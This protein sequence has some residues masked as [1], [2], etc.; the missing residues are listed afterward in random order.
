MSQ[1]LRIYVH[2]NPLNV[3]ETN[4]NI[5]LNVQDDTSWS[6]VC[7]LIKEKVNNSFTKSLAF[8]YLDEDADY[9]SGC[10]EDEWKEAIAAC[11]TRSRDELILHIEAVSTDSVA[12]QSANIKPDCCFRDPWCCYERPM[13]D[14]QII[15]GPVP[16]R[17]VNPQSSSYKYA[18][19]ALRAVTLPLGPIGGGSIALAGD[20]GL[21]EWQVVNE[22]C[23]LAHVPNSFFA[24]KVEDE[25]TNAAN[26]V[27]LQ[28]NMWYDESGFHPAPIVQDHIVPEAS[29]E[30]LKTLPGVKTIEVT[31]K[32]PIA[33]VDVTSTEVPVQVHLE[34]FNP[35]IP[36]NANDSAI[37]MIIFN[38]T[39]TNPSDKPVKVT[40]LTSLL[41]FIGWDGL[42]TIETDNMPNTPGG[43]QNTLY[44]YGG[45]I[46]AAEVPEYKEISGYY[47]IYMNNIE[48]DDKRSTNGELSIGVFHK[49][50]D[51]KSCLLQF[52]DVKG[53]WEDF[54]S[55][56]GLSGG[57][58]Q[59]GPSDKLKTWI[60]ALSCRREIQAG[61]S[62]TF[63]FLLSWHF[64][65]RYCKWGE[66]GPVTD[67][68]SFYYLGNYYNKLWPNV[69]EV[70][71]HTGQNI[72]SFTT[73][74]R[75]FR[76]AM[77]ESSL[78]WQL[79][80]SAAGRV[81]VPR[82][83]T[84]MWLEDSYL[85]CFE[86]CHPN[87]GCCPMNCTHVL[88][89][90][91]ALSRCFPDLE[92]RMR[93][94]DL[95]YNIAPNAIMPSRTTM[96]LLVKREWEDWDWC[97]KD[98]PVDLSSTRICLDGDLGTVL[99]TY[100]EIR[101]IAPQDFVDKVWPKIK[102]MMERYMNKLDSKKQ[103]LLTGAQPCTYDRGTYGIDT[104]IGCLYLCAL[105][106]A[107]E[108][109]KLMGEDDLAQIYH[110]R[111]QIGSNNLDQYCFSNG[112]WY[113]QVTPQSHPEE[114]LG[115]ATFVDALLGQWWAYSLGLG[116]LLPRDHI[117]SHLSWVFKRNHVD[118]FDFVQLPRQYFDA[119]DKGLHMAYWDVKAGEEIPKV[120]LMYSLEGA[121][122]GMEHSFAGLLL[123]EN[124]NATGFQVV[125][126]CREK[127]DGTRRSPWNEIECGDHYA[128]AMA[129]FLYFE[130]GAGMTWDILAIG[131]KALRLN[132]APICNQ[133]KFKSFFIVGS[134]WGTYSQ[135]ISNTADVQLSVLFGEV[136]IVTLG[137]VMN[138]TSAKAEID[139]KEIKTTLTKEKDKIILSFPDALVK[140]FAKSV[141][142]VLVVTAGQ[143][144]QITLS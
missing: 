25:S 90:E 96:P 44:S 43:N 138:F 31:A 8:Q 2:V 81:S 33:E 72:G 123:Y 136:D 122:S 80:D 82:T 137:L 77:F 78:P 46:N 29:K 106:A 76:D 24:I 42:S 19:E 98:D 64:P 52:T 6:D 32:Y 120:P 70:I 61:A 40:M 92:R 27:V 18:D 88:N 48:M 93:N 1:K 7:G 119:R 85:Y 62:E 54:T 130:I 16:E 56:T 5:S 26:S 115:C 104:F 66:W 94:I 132:F 129:A 22:V 3:L 134:G 133:D 116:P 124:F 114:S 65:Y 100:R 41:N 15:D 23:H 21:R 67:S 49:D 4:Q 83:P 69:K 126:E 111:F 110:Q 102:A 127:Y 57:Q 103:G 144:L 73:M 97:N 35:C 131:E 10:T 28:S 55:P 30:L 34:A 143:T 11:S 9:I 91:M 63:T 121:W 139:G 142:T 12:E 140:S 109:A 87:Q 47:G 38:Y 39:V 128:R 53:M 125:E 36:L 60:G 75:Q 101:Q 45:N 68:K 71:S 51:V 118:S 79:I 99:K 58:G 105:R 141:E 135:T 14:N 74:T 117:Q 95:L 113:T 50:E 108:M 86:G 89:Y 37:P 17:K 20:G 84:F 13:P 107:E 59:N 112:K